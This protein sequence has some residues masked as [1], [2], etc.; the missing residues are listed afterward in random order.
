MPGARGSCSFRRCGRRSGEINESF[1]AWY[2]LVGPERLS[3]KRAV[4]ADQSLS[5]PDV[6]LFSM[7]QVRL[8]GSTSGISTCLITLTL[9]T[10]HNI[11]YVITR[12]P[13]GSPMSTGAVDVM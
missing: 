11:S 13:F 9:L 6:C 10:S 8:F 3:L 12:S 7:G 2:S 4:Q 5:I 1:T